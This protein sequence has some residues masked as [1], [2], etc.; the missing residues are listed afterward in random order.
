MNI[1]EKA[2]QK[3]R[4][5]KR[6]IKFPK[7]GGKKVAQ[8]KTTNPFYVHTFK[9]SILALIGAVS[10]AVSLYFIHGIYQDIDKRSA[11]Y[12]EVYNLISTIDQAQSQYIA[13]NT[14]RLRMLQEEL[15]KLEADFLVFKE[16]GKSEEGMDKKFQDLTDKLNA[17]TDKVDQ[18]SKIRTPRTS[19]NGGGWMHIPERRGNY[20]R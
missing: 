6:K 4:K 1:L 8:K 15:K 3:I 2:I 17:L 16:H 12:Q 9:A 13:L 20:V 14:K 18:L 19:S 10:G 5:S 11:K 7:M